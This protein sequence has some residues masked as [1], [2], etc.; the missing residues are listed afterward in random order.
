MDNAELGAPEHRVQ[1]PSEYTVSQTQ[2][3]LN[4]VRDII[5]TIILSGG[6]VYGLVMFVH[7]SF[8]HPVAAATLIP[9][10]LPAGAAA[11]SIIFKKR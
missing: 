1:L 3:V 7:E 6:V 10:V 5:S 4:G 11:I 9:I 8:L 2:L